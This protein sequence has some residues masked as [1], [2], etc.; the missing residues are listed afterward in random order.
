MG[1]NPS[2]H[3][4]RIGAVAQEGQ[5]LSSAVPK[6]EHIQQGTPETMSVNG[7]GD[8][9]HH[10]VDEAADDYLAHVDQIRFLVFPVWSG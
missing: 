3:D 7:H 1:R 10:R 4:R 9:G 6:E 2:M 5:R 8:Q